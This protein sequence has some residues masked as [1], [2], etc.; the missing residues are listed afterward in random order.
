MKNKKKKQI[1]LKLSDDW[2]R[3]NGKEFVKVRNQRN[4]QIGEILKKADQFFLTTK[5]GLKEIKEKFA[6]KKIIQNVKKINPGELSKGLYPRN[7]YR[8]SFRS[9]KKMVIKHNKTTS[10]YCYESYMGALI[11]T[12]ISLTF[13]ASNKNVKD[14]VKIFNNR[15]GRP[16]QPPTFSP[17]AINKAKKELDYI[18]KNDD[19]LKLENDNL[20][21]TS[22]NGR[23]YNINL[24][25]GA[26][27]SKKK[28]YICTWSSGTRLPLPDE[29][30]AK[31]LTIA[32]K[33]KQIRTL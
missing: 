3:F 21:V 22:K 10:L 14:L 13:H 17:S 12:G 16:Y 5:K 7:G 19:H 23:I 4:Y 28:S 25:S 32:Y 26:V 31:A 15:I 9:R 27:S 8:R 24:L 20:K 2:S 6:Y 11:K 30:I 33:P 1:R 18:I 29:I